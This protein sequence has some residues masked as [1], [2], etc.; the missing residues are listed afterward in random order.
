[1]QVGDKVW[2]YQCPMLYQGVVVEIPED[3]GI[4]MVQVTKPAP[5]GEIK[6]C[7]ESRVFAL[8]DL[9]AIKVAIDSDIDFLRWQIERLREESPGET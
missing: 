9:E 4:I 7:T 5:M 8:S 1:M 6:I 2:A 3:G